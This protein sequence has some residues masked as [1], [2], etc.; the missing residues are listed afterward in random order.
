MINIE[1][2]WLK[3]TNFSKN[4]TTI[5]DEYRNLSAVGK[6][7]S[8]GEVLVYR[9]FQGGVCTSENVSIAENF[10]PSF[11]FANASGYDHYGYH[12]DR[13]VAIVGNPCKYGRYIL[14]PSNDSNDEHYLLMNGNIYTPHKKPGML[15]L[16]VDYCLE[17]IPELGLQTFVC[18]AEDLII[19]AAES[20][21][22][23]YACG[24]L[25]S[26]PFLILTIAAYSITPKLRD[27]Y[28]RTLCRYCG[29]LA[30]AFTM[31]A[32]TQLWSVHL[33][34]QACINIAFVIQ[35]SFIACFFWLNAMCIEICSLVRSYVDRETYKRMKPRT[36]FFFYSLWC[37]G[38]SIILI[39]LSMIMNLNPTIPTTYVKSNAHKDSCLFKSDTEAMPFFYVPVGLLLLGNV[40]LIALTFIKLTKYQRDLDLRRLARNQES[41]RLDRKYLRCLM[42]AAFVC[43]IIFFL[44]GLNWSMELI[45]WF[46]NADSF[47]WSSFDLVNAL[48]GVLIFG[49]FVLRKPPRDFVWQR[50]QQFRGINVIPEAEVGSMELFLL[51]IMHNN[52]A[53][54]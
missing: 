35:F 15:K 13:F 47:D 19:V 24:L 54:R 49:L 16:G 2:R 28:G 42:R 51:P 1:D 43:M 20:R 27:V 46:V 34:R 45:S 32:I 6:C 14:D 26:V 18:M 52:S 7:C 53:P 3:E 5:P 10:S 8:V 23:M 33:S 12:H 40:I 37:W 30:L 25:L 44:M 11:H 31:L 39:L 4:W 29:C 50:I 36:L 21:I 17:V 9:E 38:C 22:T 48:Q 41:D